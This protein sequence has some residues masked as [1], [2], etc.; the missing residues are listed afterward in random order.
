MTALATVL[1][2]V[3]TRYAGQPYLEAL[4]LAILIGVAIRTSWT[5]GEAWDAGIRFSAK[6]L[7]EV[8]VMLL[9]AAVSVREVATLG[10]YLL[11]GIARRGAG[12]HRVELRHLPGARARAAHGPSWW[13]AATR[14]AG[15]PPSRRWRR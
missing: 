3:E 9:G 15:T 1:Q 12:R 2:L 5:P 8:A 14:S 13:P 11:V 4:V 6:I 7:L 10:P